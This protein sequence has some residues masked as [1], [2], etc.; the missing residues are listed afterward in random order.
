MARIVGT[1]IKTGDSIDPRKAAEL[2]TIV[3]RMRASR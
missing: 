3:E 2:V 1:S